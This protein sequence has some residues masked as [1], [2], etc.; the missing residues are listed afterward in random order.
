MPRPDW[1]AT[2]ERTAFAFVFLLTQLAGLYV[3]W[4]SYEFAV[5]FNEHAFALPHREALVLAAVFEGIIFVFSA[6]SFLLTCWRR[7]HAVPSAM[8][9]LGAA[10]IGTLVGLDQLQQ[11]GPLAFAGRAI[12]PIAGVAV[13][14]MGY[15]LLK[16]RT[17]RSA[18]DAFTDIHA[19]LKA[20]LIDMLR[21]WLVN[22]SVYAV[23]NQQRYAYLHP[24]R[25]GRIEARRNR[26]ERRFRFAKKFMT[27]EQYD[28]RAARAMASREAFDE[29]SSRGRTL[30]QTE[31]ARTA[32][33]LDDQGMSIP[34]SAHVSEAVRALTT[35][36]E[37]AHVSNR[38]EQVSTGEQ[39]PVSSEHEHV[40]A[41]PTNV[42]TLRDAHEHMSVS[43]QDAPAVVES[44][45][46]GA[47]RRAVAAPDTS[48]QT[49]TVSATLTPAP[50]R[51]RARRGIT[52]EQ[53][54]QIQAMKSAGSTQ[55]Q[56][57]E[58]LGIAN[59]SVAKHWHK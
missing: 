55:R 15:W 26:A 35:T 48:E 21:A 38:R 51:S 20:W 14:E 37:H 34:A 33:Q 4:N 19:A 23:L 54:E 5:K 18:A 28:A 57:A 8:A 47:L 17:L 39:P 58:A 13:M 29:L 49:G 44:D 2:G 16:Q 11:H 42:V 7:S 9:I 45:I 43:A 3:L 40:S 53:I 50:G 31:K 1:S 59:G 36:G 25:T 32:G 22:R 46:T 12:V 52:S 30:A 41:R 10:F 24:A 56:V 27:D 6:M